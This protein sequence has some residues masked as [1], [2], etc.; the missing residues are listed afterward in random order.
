[1]RTERDIILDSVLLLYLL[2][3]AG[4]IRGNLKTQKTTFLAELALREQGLHGP[5]FGFFRYKNGP[6]SKDLAQ[7]YDRLVAGGFL[8]P[9]TA[10]PT[11]RGQFLLGLAFPQL[12]EQNEAVFASMD[13]TLAIYRAWNGRQLME[14]VYSLTVE[15]DGWPGMR[16][17]VEKIPMHMDI[18]V[19]PPGGLEVDN[20][21]L[22]LVLEELSITQEEIE[23][24]ER[25]WPETEQRA[26]KRL[27]DAILA[28]ERSRGILPPKGPTG[29]HSE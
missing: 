1:M 5:H 15:P 6:F 17:P 4:E 18:L 7:T 29:E 2:D 13:E 28:A 21:T 8:A 20:D 27:T 12:R 23:E 9:E 24:A 19:P 16:L 25:D 22:A 14:H 26:I 11:E 10:K 3:G